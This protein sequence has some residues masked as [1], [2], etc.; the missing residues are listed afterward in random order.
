VGDSPTVDRH[1]CP[2]RSLIELPI[3]PAGRFR[4]AQTHRGLPQGRELDGFVAKSLTGCP[5]TLGHLSSLK[6]AQ[7]SAVAVDEIVWFQAP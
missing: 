7:A 2:L 3:L 4:E 5:G 6:N 1:R